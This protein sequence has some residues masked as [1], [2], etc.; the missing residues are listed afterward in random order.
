MDAT[1][2]DHKLRQ[3]RLPVVEREIL[4]LEEAILQDQLPDSWS[5]PTARKVSAKTAD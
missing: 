1:N 2:T 5:I 3:T 4:D